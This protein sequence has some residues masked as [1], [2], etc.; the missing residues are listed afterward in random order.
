MVEATK[1]QTDVIE[2]LCD[3]MQ[4]DIDAVEAYEQAIKNIE[5]SAIK[6]NITSFKEDHKRHI[7]ELS[8][9]I[10]SLGGTPPERSKD[11]KGFIIKGMTAIQ[12]SLGENQA[13]HAMKLNEKLTNKMYK[14][15]LEMSLPADVRELVEKNY[16]D[17]KRHLSYINQQLDQ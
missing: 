7:T 10:I 8:A 11:L 2:K 6:Q 12:S 16:A 14:N 1:N 9:Q 17:E 15:A 13:L 3:L 5:T 4:L